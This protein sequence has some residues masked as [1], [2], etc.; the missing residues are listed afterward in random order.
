MT[1]TQLNEIESILKQNKT[2][3][4]NARDH[5]KE[6]MR[7]KYEDVDSFYQKVMTPEEDK[8]LGDLKQEAKAAN[9]IYDAFI[10]HDWK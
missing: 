5:Y 8:M 6:T 2:T 3:K 9:D 10:N 1:L 4:Q 7:E